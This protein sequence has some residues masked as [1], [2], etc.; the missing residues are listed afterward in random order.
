VIVTPPFDHSPHDP[1]YIKAYVPGVRE[2]GGQYTHAGVWTLIAYAL[3]GDGDTAFDVFGMLNPVSRASTR[4]GIHA[5]RVE[6][7]VVAA[8]VYSSSPHVRLGGWTWYTGAAGWLYRAGLE[9]I[10]GVRIRAQ[11]R[12]IHDR[13]EG[14]GD[15]ALYYRDILLPLHDRIVNE[16]QLQYNAMQLGPFQLLRAREQQIQTA[17]TYIEALRDYWFARADLGQLLS[18]EARD[19]T[20]QERRDGGAGH[21]LNPSRWWT[22]SLNATQGEGSS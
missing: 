10:L 6:P 14:A 22:L 19:D 18:G 3:L 20:D 7:Y 11:A 13:L 17:V 4:T 16:T 5:Y 15:R 21:G 2:N 12:I 1:G 8:D 9:W